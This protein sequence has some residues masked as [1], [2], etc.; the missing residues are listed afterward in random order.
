MKRALFDI[1]H[2]T[3]DRFLI[4]YDMSHWKQGEGHPS[5]TNDAEHVVH[6]LKDKLDGRR[7]LY[8]DTQGVLS[9]LIVKDGQFLSFA[10]ATSMKCPAAEP[11]IYEGY[12]EGHEKHGTLEYKGMMTV[13]DWWKQ[14]K[15]A[16][17]GPNDGLS[18]YFMPTFEW[19]DLTYP[20]RNK[21]G[22]KLPEQSRLH[23]TVTEGNES[24]LVHVVITWPSEDKNYGYCDTIIHGKC[25]LSMEYCWNMAEYLNSVIND[26]NINYARAFALRELAINGED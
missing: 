16:L 26:H 3:N 1:H 6:S 8:F 19:F 20:W 5:I 10:P 7:L 9:E 24:A 25:F 13:G 17:P 22:D 14:I 23:T 18:E 12:P 4:I 11:W 15:A 2:H 21:L